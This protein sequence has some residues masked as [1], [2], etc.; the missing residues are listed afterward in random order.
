MA[1]DLTAIAAALTMAG[2]GIAT[3]WTQKIVGGA[4]VG[5]MAEKPELFGRGLVLMAL[6][7]TIVVFGLIIALQLLARVV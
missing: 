5:A 7:E 2:T 1:G 4:T 6:P 3:A